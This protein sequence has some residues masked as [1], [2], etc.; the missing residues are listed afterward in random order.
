MRVWKRLSL[1]I[2]GAVLYKLLC[3]SVYSADCLT[4]LYFGTSVSLL[5]FV[6]FVFEVEVQALVVFLLTL[7]LKFRSLGTDLYADRL[8]QSLYLDEHKL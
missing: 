5:S 4:S 7:S 2:Q 1:T 3:R 8:M 6:D